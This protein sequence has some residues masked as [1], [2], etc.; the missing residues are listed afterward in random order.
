MTTQKKYNKDF[1]KSWTRDM[2][3]FLGFFCADGNMV[4][5]KRGGHYISVYS[6]DRTIIVDL[7]KSIDSKHKI[8]G[9]VS[10][11]AVT[12]RF[13]IGSKEIFED[14]C[15]LG[16]TPNKSHRMKIPNVPKEYEADFIRGYF[17]GDGNVW[18][19]F[20]KRNESKDTYKILV[21]FTSASRDFLVDLKSILMR[22]GIGGGSIFNIKGKNCSRL[23]FSTEDA[24]KLYKIMYN[25]PHKLFLRRKKLVFD[26]FIKM[27]A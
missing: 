2:A 23:S 24:L 10:P 26:R 7:M 3:Y 20:L 12:Y 14:L 1:F 8:S 22:L 13:Q 11:T 27:R 15:K 19:G 5:N 18:T 9:R 25:K 4:K 17:D 16:I 6:A 21:G